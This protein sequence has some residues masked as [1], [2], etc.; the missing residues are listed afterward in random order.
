MYPPRPE[1]E[2]ERETDNIDLP[3]K[4]ILLLRTMPSNQNIHR[5]LLP[6]S[7]HHPNLPTLL[8]CPKH[9]HR[10]LG[11][12]HLHRLRSAMPSHTRLLGPNR[13]RPMH[14]PEQVPNHQP[15]LQRDHRL[16]DPGPPHPDDLEPA[17]RMAGQASPERRL[18]AGDL[19]LL[20][21]YLPDRRAVLDQS[22]G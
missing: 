6:S 21:E 20:R 22:R 13:P 19:R 16:R 3:G 8:L 2:G 4:P 17:T 11:H 1:E 7:L 10:R 18:R 9:S 14:G 12:S 15:S 5:L